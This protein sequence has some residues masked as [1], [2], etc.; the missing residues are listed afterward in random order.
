MGKRLFSLNCAGI[1]R[2]SY[3]KKSELLYHHTEK[4]IP[5]DS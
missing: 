1:I 2:Y 3:G 5:D 4:L